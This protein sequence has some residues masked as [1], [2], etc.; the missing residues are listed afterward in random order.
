MA[1]IIKTMRYQII[2]PL[3]FDWDMFGQVLYKIQ[4]DTRQIMNKTIQFCWEWQGY[5][6]DYKAERG[7]YPPPR[8]TL[9]YSGITGYCYNQLKVEFPLLQ[10]G[11]LAQSINRAILRWK[12]DA[13]DILCG[14][15]SIPC[16]KK[17]VP[18]DLHK[19]SIQI[20]KNEHRDYIVRVS[21]L[22]NAGKKDVCPS[23]PFNILLRASDK[24]Q[25]V[26]L[27]RI[28]SG[29]YSHGSS[30]IIYHKR[31]RKWFLNLNYHFEVKETLLDPNK[32]LG[33]DLG[34]VY[35]LYATFNDSLKR[36]KID[37]GEIETFRK[38]I[39]ARRISMLRQG[40][41]S[42]DGRRGHGRIKKLEPTNALKHKIAN[43]RDTAN[44]KYSRYAVDLALQHGCGIIQMEDLKGIR[45]NNRFLANW[46]Y[47]DLQQKI[48]YKAK[49]NGI[50]V[51]YIDPRYTSQRCSV[52]GYID[53]ENRPEQAT[54]ICKACGFEAN[55]DYN[56]ARNIATKDIDQ[57]IEATVR[58]KHLG[59]G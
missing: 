49:E 53:R 9:G 55:A 19:N 58:I 50:T 38:R 29:E 10:T 31:K 44:H 28:L 41:Y 48:E 33:I 20:T 54:F 23:K 15:K 59:D 24:T 51:K 27:D 1:K 21:L 8:V 16:Y 17:D 22:S 43:F 35:P 14:N 2:K 40:K 18:I 3:S 4:H 13:K 46:T 6:S 30:Q 47:Y 52:C 26:I 39:V 56:A 25:R 34:I 57:I 37:G 5:S 32:I 7:I 42:G 36:F 12:T 45:G 11:N